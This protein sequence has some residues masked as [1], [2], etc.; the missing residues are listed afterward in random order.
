M[1]EPL[2][3]FRL[4]WLF[5]DPIGSLVFTLLQMCNFLLEN[6][7][8]NAVLFTTYCQYSCEECDTVIVVSP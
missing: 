1:D 8:S 6:A 3:L 2:S 5:L 4:I 7:V